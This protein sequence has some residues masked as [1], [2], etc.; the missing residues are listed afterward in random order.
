[1]SRCK[2]IFFECPVFAVSS[3]TSAISSMIKITTSSV[4]KPNNS[5][6][7]TG[8]MVEGEAA[9]AGRES[10][11]SAVT[12]TFFCFPFINR[13]SAQSSV[14]LFLSPDTPMRAAVFFFVVLFLSSQMIALCL[15]PDGAMPPP[16]LP[17][18]PSQTLKA[19]TAGACH[20]SSKM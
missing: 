4:I 17:L 18:F 13:K 12:L 5:V 1:M 7:E 2:L 8:G 16:F 3:S 10:L 19:C 6:R 14:P 9:A 15:F 11:L 20:G